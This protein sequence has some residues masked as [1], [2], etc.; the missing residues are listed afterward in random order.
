MNMNV[1]LVRCRLGWAVLG[2]VALVLQG[3][4]TE[5]TRP[6]YFTHLSLFVN[7]FSYF[8]ILTNLFLTIWFVLAFRSRQMGQARWWGD[9]PEIKGALL[10]AGTVTIL[11]YWTLLVDIP[12]P[13]VT[14]EIAN[15]LLHLLVPLGLWIDWLIVGDPMT[16]SYG[17]M[18][19]AWLIFP[20]VF[21]IYTE[22]RGPFAHWYPYFFLDP[23]AVGGT[24][25]LIVSIIGMMLLF[26]VVAS[27]IFWLYQK[28]GSLQIVPAQQSRPI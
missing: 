7:F 15:F 24:G 26:V 2:I 19:R 3:I 13:T 8:T 22:V 20:L 1:V 25:T 18:L 16:K 11:V 9:Q 12:I 17:V 27:L 28:R 6:G 14:G 4:A 23:Q 5:M 10:V 21:V